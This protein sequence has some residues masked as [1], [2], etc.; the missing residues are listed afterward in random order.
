[1]DY[2]SERRINEDLSLLWKI[3]E[4]KINGKYIINSITF[5]SDIDGKAGNKPA[6]RWLAN[7]HFWSAPLTYRIY[8]C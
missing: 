7:F 1:V 8:G 6:F 2:P 4:R 5:L 3:P